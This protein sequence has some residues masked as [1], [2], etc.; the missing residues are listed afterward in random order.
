MADVAPGGDS[1]GHRAQMLV[2]GGLA[3]AVTIVALGLILNLAIF[4]ENLTTRD[5]NQ[6]A[7]DATEYQTTSV[8]SVARASRYVNL[9][10]KGNLA[11][12]LDRELT[13]INDR[14]ARYVAGQGGLANVSVVSTETG[15]RIRQDDGT[16]NFTNVSGASTWT[17]A[18]DVGET[19]RFFQTIKRGGLMEV[20]L[21]SSLD[22][23]RLNAYHVVIRDSKDGTFENGDDEVYRVFVFQD[24]L[25]D[26]VY[27]TVQE[28][29]E[30]FADKTLDS[31][32]PC[33][34]QKAE[35][36]VDLI[37]NTFGGN[38]CTDELDFFDGSMSSTY[39]IK[40]N[41]TAD[42]LGATKGTYDILID[43][44][45]LAGSTASNYASSPSDDPYAYTAFFEA[46]VKTTYRTSDVAVTTQRRTHPVAT[47]SS[48]P[49]FRPRIDTGTVQD[50]SD[51]TDASY[52]VTWEVSDR[53]GDLD[54]VRLYLT[55]RSANERKDS[56]T[57]SVSGDRAGPQTNTLSELSGHGGDYVIRIVVIDEN[58]NVV[59]E[60]TED[61]ADGTDP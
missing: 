33:T 24:G 35:V 10:D 48:F 40:Y 8:E 7:A 60:K 27:L 49:G 30:S 59:S 46:T 14:R 26:N 1:V 12:G 18:T 31:L 61:T 11:S 54:E 29:G 57:V 55:N 4:T 34:T 41:N 9:N 44:D 15:T 38:D 51:G 45:S 56:T 36:E 23:L 16:R 19:A 5:V 43:K 20:A 39:A 37:R 47:L 42:L 52:D 32:D 2:V 3:L 58:G 13:R 25:T 21:S 53:D 17:L 50:N 22:D 6:E 28:P